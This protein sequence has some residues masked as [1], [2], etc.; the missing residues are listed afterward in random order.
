[1]VERSMLPNNLETI[2]IEDFQTLVTD[3]VP[4]GKTIEYKQD[5]YQLDATDSNYRIKQH[6]E[7]LKD[8]SS[9]ANTIGGDLIIGLKEVNGI[10]VEVCG[11]ATN[12]PD[13][14]ML[15][16][17]QIVQNGIEPRLSLTIQSVEHSP[18]R[19]V[20]I[21][22]NRQ[23]IIAPHRVVYQKSFG[24]FYS[25]TSSGAH[26]MDT[27]ELRQSF[28]LS[29]SMFHRIRSF[30]EERFKLIMS[31]NTPV[32]LKKSPKLVLHLIPQDSFVSKLD[33]SIEV[34]RPLMLPLICQGG[35][36]TGRC[37][38]DGIVTFNRYAAEESSAYVQFFRNGIIESAVD[39]LMYNS[40]RDPHQPQPYLD[41]TIFGDMIRV[42]P[43]YL[44]SLLALGVSPPIWC[45]IAL[46]DAKGIA[47]PAKDHYFPKPPIDR[48]NLQLPEFE[49][50]DL[51]NVDVDGFFQPALDI[52][53]NA[54]GHDKCLNYKENGKYC[55]R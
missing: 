51:H 35:S 12:N 1:M 28:T 29:E 4:E 47:I 21:L 49:I 14:L 6:E 54:G 3:S 25:R 27:S 55:V 31:S 30:R 44:K 46:L 53:W 24:Q 10:A 37:N 40:S 26:Q 48:D 2:T 34:M 19:S 33:F 11:F 36:R 52:L 23:S 41:T 22:R 43:D 7:M 5:F 39:G 8:I 16:I 15:R 13:A 17:T 9:F 20:F 50:T 45:T 38:F 42:F 18:G 32:V